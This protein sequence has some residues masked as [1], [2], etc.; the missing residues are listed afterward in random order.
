[1]TLTLGDRFL[2]LDREAKRRGLAGSVHQFDLTQAV[3]ALAELLGYEVPDILDL[4]EA[5]ARVRQ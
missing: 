4:T 5:P 3:L 1:M 2:M